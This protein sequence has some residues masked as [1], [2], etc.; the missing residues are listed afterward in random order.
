MKHRVVVLLIVLAASAVSPNLLTAQIPPQHRS[1]AAERYDSVA[2]A[3]IVDEGMNRSQVMESLS[4][5]TDVCGG[6]LTMSPGYKKAV[7]WSMNT[8][9]VWGL[10]NV[11]REGW[12]PFGRGWWVKRLEANVIEPVPFP[13][14][15][16]PKAW[17]PG[18]DGTVTGD[19]INFDAKTD[20]AVASFKGKLKGKIV[21]LGDERPLKAHFEPEAMRT[22]DSSLLVMANAEP[23]IPR[24]GRRQQFASNPEARR[25]LQLENRKFTMCVEEDAA[26]VL[27]P[28]RGDGGT[29][30]VQSASLPL[31][32]GDTSFQSRPRIQDLKAP[33]TIPQFAV[34]AE[35]YNRIV[36]MLRKGQGVR[37]EMRL[38]V[39]FTRED[40]AYN[41]I[42]EIPGSNL[43]DEVVMIGGHLDSWHGGTGA[44]DDGTGVATGMEAI[45]IIKS[46]GLKPR[47]TIR[48]ALWSAEEQGLLGSRAYVRTHFGER[49][50][51]NPTAEVQWKPEGEKFCAYFNNDNG[52][53]KVRGIYLQGNEALRPIFRAWFAP[54]RSMGAST[55]TP[56]STGST[57]HVSFD[58][59]GLP[60]F[61]WIQDPIEYGARTWH[62]TMDVYDRAQEEDLKQA[63]VIMAAFAYNAAMREERL[64]RK[65][66]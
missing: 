58:A 5:L 36:R 42:A 23:E 22:S 34:A 32:Q 19:V 66:Q 7:E 40:S 35:H 17:S 3:R 25:L 54:F 30:F 49:A 45:R 65:R 13:L 56:L 61:Q 15:M 50:G 37:V 59:I 63:S 31:G 12:G 18:T 11:H 41:V 60:A 43:K 16:Y 55:I 1:A 47:R 38:E 46:L 21:L 62:S 4:W 27:T 26:A 2:V 10:E 39:A 8:M 48:I 57:D 51:N 44:T 29:I 28:S 52:T 20:S 53:G 24:R 6:R 14:L 33:S 9:K 64:P